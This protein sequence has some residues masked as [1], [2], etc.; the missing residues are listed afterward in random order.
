MRQVRALL[1]TRSASF[2]IL[3]NHFACRKPL[4]AFAGNCLPVGH[5]T[6]LYRTLLEPDTVLR[7]RDRF[8]R[9]DPKLECFCNISMS[10]P[11]SIL[12]FTRDRS[13]CFPILGAIFGPFLCARPVPSLVDEHGA[14][15][16][17][18]LAV[19]SLVELARPAPAPSALVIQVGE[20]HGIPNVLSDSTLGN[21]D[22]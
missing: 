3:R 16:L 7:P 18:E 4:K 11:P 22:G 19:V 1:I 17:S 10:W 20:V 15:C 5:D 2:S 21:Q 8:E 6:N 12:S 13:I 14:V 9:F